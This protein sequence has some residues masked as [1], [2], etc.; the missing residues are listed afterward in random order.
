MRYVPALGRKDTAFMVPMIHL[1]LYNPQG[2]LEGNLR[3]TEARNRNH[4][5]KINY[6]NSVLSHQIKIVDNSAWNMEVQP[7]TL[8]LLARSGE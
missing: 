6:K 2:R 4:Q 7:D 3:I 1:R 8:F 5:M